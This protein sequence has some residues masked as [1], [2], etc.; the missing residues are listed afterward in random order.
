MTRLQTPA[1]SPLYDR[2]RERHGYLPNYARP[3]A[4]APAAYDA[5]ESLAASIRH[6]LDERR[7]ELATFVAAQRLGSDYCRLAHAAVLRDRHFDDETVRALTVDWRQAGLDGA[8]VA[9][10][11]LADRMAADPTRVAAADVH[12]LRR[13]GLSDTDIFHVV[14]AVAARRF[15]TAVLAAT[16]TAPDDRLVDAAERGC[17]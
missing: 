7:Y 15:F 16:G 12:A 5:W 13:H 4:L 17:R 6:G 1:G 8:D 9:V 10:L 2:L 3:F 14:L 11:E